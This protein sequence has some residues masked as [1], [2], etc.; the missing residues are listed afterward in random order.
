MTVLSG[1]TSAGSSFVS[2]A[3]FGHRPRIPGTYAV[4]GANGFRKLMPL[5]EPSDGGVF[6][7]AT[8][9][10]E[11]FRARPLVQSLCH[12]F[13][14]SMRC[15]DWL[16]AIDHCTR[17]R[18]RDLSETEKLSARRVSSSAAKYAIRGLANIASPRKK[19]ISLNPRLTAEAAAWDAA[20]VWG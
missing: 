6:R 12:S 10:S 20:V 11:C 2:A 7:R 15:D 3:T 19:T 1:L 4:G 17:K 9:G 13:E 5:A 8:S 16:T 18:L 14:S